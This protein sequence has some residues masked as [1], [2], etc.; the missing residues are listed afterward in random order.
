MTTEIKLADVVRL[1]KAHPCGGYEW[2]MVGVGADIA[3]EC[4]KCQR[5]LLLKREAFR[6]RVKQPVPKGA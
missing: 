5:R 4:L 6:R 3:L 2:E 1:P